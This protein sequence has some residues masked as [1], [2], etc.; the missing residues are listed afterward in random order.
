[1]LPT[2]PAGAAAFPVGPN[3]IVA[4][5]SEV[6]SPCVIATD[7]VS[8]DPETGVQARFSVCELPSVS[9][10]GICVLMAEPSGDAGRFAAKVA[11]PV[12]TG[13]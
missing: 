8:G 6:P 3:A 10:T 1:M 4:D 5:P 12:G 7:H 2:V 13:P 9:V 11:L